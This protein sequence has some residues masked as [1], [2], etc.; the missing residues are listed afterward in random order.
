MSFVRAVP[1]IARRTLSTYKTSTGLVGLDVD[2]N[3]RENL[4]KISSQILSA[5]QVDLRSDKCQSYWDILFIMS[6]TDTISDTEFLLPQKIPADNGYRV[7]V[8]KWYNFITKSANASHDVSTV[9]T[10]YLSLHSTD[11]TI[12]FVLFGD[13]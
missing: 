13:H 11:Y 5:V 9:R 6:P 3:G 4:L 1:K 2:P 10:F 7:N 12:Y 8:E